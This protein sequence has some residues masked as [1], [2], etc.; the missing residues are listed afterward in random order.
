MNLY[1]KFSGKSY[2]LLVIDTT[3]A[4]DNPLHLRKSFRKNIELILTIDDKITY[5]KLRNSTNRE[6]AKVSALL[7]KIDKY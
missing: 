6:A 2:S 1:K 5:E 7:E 3:L 4:S